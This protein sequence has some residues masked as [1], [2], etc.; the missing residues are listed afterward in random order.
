LRL[1]RKL[2]YLLNGV[3]MRGERI[4]SL[5]T[6]SSKSNSYESLR[7]KG[8]SK[9]RSVTSPTRELTKK[10]KGDLGNT[11]LPRPAMARRN[12]LGGNTF[13]ATKKREEGRTDSRPL[14]QLE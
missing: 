2:G 1:Q 12:R 14:S 7:D 4:K 10:E 13:R 6:L 5:E 8:R 9:G 3:D 11:F